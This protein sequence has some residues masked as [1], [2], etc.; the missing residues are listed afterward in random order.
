MITTEA[1]PQE[2]K[3]LA[4]EDKCHSECL[5]FLLGVILIYAWRLKIP[6]SGKDH[7]HWKTIKG[8]QLDIIL[9]LMVAKLGFS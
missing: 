1:I 7:V 2:N 8:K 5:L 4:G 6:N 3:H 9:F